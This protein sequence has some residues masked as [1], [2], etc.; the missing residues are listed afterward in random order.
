MPVPN[1]NRA[2]RKYLISMHY[3]KVAQRHGPKFLECRLRPG[4]SVSQTSEVP[5]NHL[6]GRVSGFRAQI[7][8]TGLEQAR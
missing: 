2:A 7:T 4:G 8:P 6:R 3:V 1:S 5:T